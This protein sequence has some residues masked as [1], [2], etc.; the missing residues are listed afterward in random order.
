MPG[1]RPGGG[2][3]ARHQAAT[4]GAAYDISWRTACPEM[5][6]ALDDATAASS[7][8]QTQHRSLDRLAL[9]P[10]TASP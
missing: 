10:P 8:I 9:S 6:M 4:P 5:S 1:L 2:V 7:E 3:R